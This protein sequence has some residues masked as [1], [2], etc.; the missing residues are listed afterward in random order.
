MVCVVHRSAEERKRKKM[1]ITVCQLSNDI[2]QFEEEW[3][4]LVSHCE[5][6]KSEILL[7]PEMPFYSWIANTPS[8][9]ESKK[10]EAVRAHEKWLP[11]IEE[12]GDTIVAYSK[13]VIE[14][15]RFYNTAFIWTKEAGHQKVHTKYFFPEEAGFYEGTWFDR[16]QK[17]FELIE[18]N[19]LRIGFLLCTEIW[20]TQYTRKYGLEGM[21]FLLC[22]RASGKSSTDQWVRCGQTS[23][24][25]GGAY[26][27]SSNRSGIGED[28]FE[29]GGT[30]WISQPMDGA[31]LGV[32]SNDAPFLTVDVD[33]TK[34]KQAKEDYPIYVEE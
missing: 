22:P 1:K 19:G 3:E 24:V 14:E 28:G 23:S 15:D 13:P 6:N 7:L 11:R 9:D 34:S 32:T 31:L 10:I 21:D 27:L 33:I 25:I 2:K 5:R 4:A 30:G 17:N 16:E 20:F 26:C 8:I 12:F 18:I 29:W